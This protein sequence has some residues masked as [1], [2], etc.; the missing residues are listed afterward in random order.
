M[1]HWGN[2]LAEFNI[3]PCIVITYTYIPG[4]QKIPSGKENPALASKDLNT[5]LGSGSIPLLYYLRS[6][7]RVLSCIIVSPRR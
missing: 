1:L 7:F 6:D 3:L 2:Q 5:A 4:Y